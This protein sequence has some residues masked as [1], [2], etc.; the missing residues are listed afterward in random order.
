VTLSSPWTKE[1]KNLKG[2]PRDFRARHESIIY[3]FFSH[4]AA[5]NS[6]TC[7]HL[8]AKCCLAMCFRENEMF[9]DEHVKFFLPHFIKN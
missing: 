5:R 2:G 7:P 1:R 8:I 4:S 9:F 6:F 3:H